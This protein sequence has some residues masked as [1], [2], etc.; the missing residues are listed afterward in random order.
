MGAPA[1]VRVTWAGGHRFDTGRPDGPTLRLDASGETGQSPVDAVLS[2][3]A[4]CVSADVVDILEKRRTPV[5]SLGVDVIGDRVD[6][7]PR[8]FKHITLQFTIAGDSLDRTQVERAIDLSVTKYC[9][10]RDSLR[11]D[12]A[13]EWTLVLES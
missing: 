7:T 6:T 5:R 12:I 8:R 11:E 2:G 10:V 3:I 9:S 4:S 1:V 13:V